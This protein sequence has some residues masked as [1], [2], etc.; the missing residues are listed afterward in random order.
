MQRNQ[1]TFYKSFWE[2]IQKLP[3][4]TEKLQACEMLTQYGLTQTEP[5]FEAIKPSVAMLF[6][7]VRPVM[8]TAHKRAKMM[9]TVNKF[10]QIP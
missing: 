9:Q 4:K 1:F 8:D 10:S 6:H 3:T 2:V 7:M 5:D